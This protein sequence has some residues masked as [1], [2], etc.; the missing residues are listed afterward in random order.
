MF[1]F[2]GLTLEAIPPPAT[3]ERSDGGQVFPFRTPVAE[4]SSLLGKAEKHA[5]YQN[6]E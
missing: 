4:R 5:P 2:G 6:F 3:P 1:C